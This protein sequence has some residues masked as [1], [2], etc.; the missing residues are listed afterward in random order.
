MV[1]GAVVDVDQQGVIVEARQLHFAVLQTQVTDRGVP[2]QGVERAID[3]CRRI[4]PMASQRD[5]RGA[6]RFETRH[7]LRADIAVGGGT[8][9]VT[10]RQIDHS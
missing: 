3:V 8:E 1:Q 10:R 6:I 9:L 7:F 2:G 4:L 5:Q